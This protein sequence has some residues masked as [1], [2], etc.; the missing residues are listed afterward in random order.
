MIKFK[1]NDYLSLRLEDGNT[2]I[3]INNKLFRQCKYLLLNI[4]TSENEIIKSINSIDDA[5]EKL[6]NSLESQDS[7]FFN[8][9]PETQFWGHCSNFQVWYENN[10]D[11]CLLHRSL[12][13]PLLKELTIAGDKSA[14][15]K[16]KDEIFRRFETGH[17]T[18][19]Q[20]LL[21]N[22]YL[23]Y[24]N[25]EEIECLLNETSLNITLNISNELKTLWEDKFSNFWKIISILEIIL[26]I[27]LKY[28]KNY[29]FTIIEYLPEEINREFVKKLILYLNY[30]EFRKYKISY[31]KFFKLFESI[32]EYLYKNYPDILKSLEGGYISSIMSLDEMYSFGTFIIN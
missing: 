5:I 24:L 12:A 30:K 27:A 18:I 15:Q 10:Y 8:I 20:F 29:F 9:S 23:N 7:K 21:Y 6:N 17:L 11:S 13:F 28:D 22:D 14:Q 2:N 4:P 16:F 1:L 19:I 31:G 32:I 26:F 25:K 3:Y